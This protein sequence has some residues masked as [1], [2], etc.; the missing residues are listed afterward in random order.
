MFCQEHSSQEAPLDMDANYDPNGQWVRVCDRCF[1]T[2]S[3]TPAT[4]AEETPISAVT[5]EVEKEPA[6]T[7]VRD[8]ASAPLAANKKQRASIVEGLPGGL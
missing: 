6:E 3:T 8:P 1:D 7:L 5:E 2:F 4:Q